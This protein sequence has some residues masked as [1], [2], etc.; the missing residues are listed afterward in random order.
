[1]VT[2]DWINAP[3]ITSKSPARRVPEVGQK[4]TKTTSHIRAKTT[5]FTACFSEEKPKTEA[6]AANYL[7]QFLVQENLAAFGRKIRKPRNF[8]LPDFRKG[9]RLPTILWTEMS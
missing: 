5:H 1:L 4:P 9:K 7:K 8:L 2:K 6:R 3:P